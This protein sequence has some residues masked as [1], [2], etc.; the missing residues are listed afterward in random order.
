MRARTDRRTLAASSAD[1]VLAVFFILAT[2]LLAWIAT[3]VAGGSMTALPHAFYVP[4]IIAAVRFGAPGAL[5]AAVAAGVAAG[6]LMPLDVAAGSPQLLTNWM[7][8]LVTFVIIGQ[9]TAYLS[10]HSLPS[11]TEEIL[12]RRFRREIADAIDMRQLRLE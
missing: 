3:S 1:A 7:T 12:A 8:R 10:R 4:V 2:L 9:L 5:V 6:P 11:L